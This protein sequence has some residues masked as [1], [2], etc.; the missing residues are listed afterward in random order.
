VAAKTWFV[1]ND[2]VDGWQEMRD[3]GSPGANATSSPQTGWVVG[4]GATNHSEFA[5]RTNRASSTFTGTTVPDGSLDTTLKDAWRSDQ[6][7]TGDFASANWTVHF[8]AIGVTQA[9]AQD[10]RMRC[11]LFKANADGSSATEITS[12]HQQGGLITNLSTTQ[13]VSTATFNPGAFSVAGQYIFVQLAWERTGAGGMSTTDVAMRVGDTASRVIS[14]DFTPGA[15]SATAS[16]ATI[17]V[18]AKDV[19]AAPGAVSATA[20]K[21]AV[22]VSA[23]DATAQPGAVSATAQSASIVVTAQDASGETTGG[24]GPQS[25]TA[26]AAAITVTARDGSGVPGAVS[27]A[28]AAAGIVVTARDVAAQPGAVAATA[29]AA[30]I[31]VQARNVS[32][33]PG[34]VV[35]T[36]QSAAIVVSA[37]DA[38]AQL[39]LV[40]AAATAVISVAARDVTP[41]AGP[42]SSVAMLASILVRALDA[43]LTPAPSS[44]APVIVDGVGARQASITG[45]GA[46][47][48]ARHGEGATQT[49][50]VGRED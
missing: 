16:A 24:S 47:Q 33:A 2:A 8:A 27:A 25:A 3:N 31:S 7:L 5:T 40:A 43:D 32:A 39:L 29:L 48:A 17:N 34:P 21:A 6:A 14:S 18:S 10:G 45:T 30:A 4:T 36:A 37:R 38:S 35:A 42:V 12:A 19:T 46:G 11:R 1:R 22:T 44:Y 9:G 20:E 13:Q 26:E 23:K 28:A 41:I 15:Q 50:L 49:P